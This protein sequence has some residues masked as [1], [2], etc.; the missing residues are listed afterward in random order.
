MPPRSALHDLTKQLDALPDPTYVV[1]ERRRI[2][3][4]NKACAAWVGRSVEEL[5]GREVRYRSDDVSSDPIAA[6]AD[7]LCPPP[8]SL[9]GFR[10]AGE[11]VLP[12]AVGE[13]RQPRRAEFIPLGATSVGTALVLC[14]VP[15]P[16]IAERR[17][18]SEVRA[19]LE[20]QR[21]HALTAQA[22]RD[23]ATRY[24]PERLLGVSSAIERVRRQIALAAAGDASVLIV[25][26][27]GVGKAHTAR[28]IHAARAAVA[29]DIETAPFAALDAPT[30]TAES[31]QAA[32]RNLHRQHAAATSRRGGCLLLQHVDR[33]PSD[34][35]AELAGFLRLGE[36]PLRLIATTVE[37]LAAAVA[38][39]RFRADL[40]AW[41]STLVVEIPGLAAR[42]EDVPPLAQHFVEATNLAGEKQLGGCTSEALDLLSQ[43][44]WPGNVQELAAVVTAACASAEGPL[45]T[46]RELPRKLHL[47]ADADRY[48]ARPDETIVLDEYLAEI[49]KELLRRAL[50]RAKGNKTRAARLVGL[51][52][53][54]LYR[55]LV[56]LGLE[57]GAVVFEETD[58]DSATSDD[59][60]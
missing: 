36:F 59:E 29:G 58:G 8:T 23:L 4:V 6:V 14:T 28:T 34:A 15:A 56:Q 54:R 50:E 35:Q 3:F 41:L 2:V 32:I 51:T 26:P 45:V 22:R 57:T 25:G 43:Y 27:S 42:P 49:E 7:A 46:V 13:Q 17:S 37:P 44:A 60:A 20:S 9:A 48:A 5:V 1:D 11:I 55:R 10:S 30:L 21:L 52:R 39:G 12:A 38:A 53:P 47:A 40:A 24:A 16:E 19:E 31:L 18:E 33:L